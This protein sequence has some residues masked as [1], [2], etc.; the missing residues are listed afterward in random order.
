M[1]NLKH[2]AQVTNT[3]IKCV[4]VFRE[5]YNE[6]GHVVDPNHCLV[7]ETDRL[8][9]HAHDDVVRVVESATAQEVNQFYEIANRSYFS[10]GTPMLQELHKRGWLKK[11]P[12]DNITLTP[13]R[14]TSVKLSEINEVIRQ[15][16]SGLTESDIKNKAVDDTDKPPRTQTTLDSSQTIDQALPAAGEGVLDDSAIAQN[17][18]SQAETF[19]A[20]A[21]RLQDEAYEMAPNLKPKRGR[22]TSPKK[23]T[24]NANT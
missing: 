14:S 9:D 19:L 17:M 5:I 15:Q 12:T 1:A 13:N 11:Y 6:L 10:D 2:I 3:G 4:V 16:S 20:E 18:L 24:T 8:P 23:T 7:V 22:K 21:K